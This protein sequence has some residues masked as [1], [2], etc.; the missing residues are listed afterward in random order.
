MTYFKTLLLASFTAAA[1]SGCYIH[2]HEGRYYRDGYYHH[3]HDHDSYRDR[4]RD[5][6]G[7][8]DQD[9]HRR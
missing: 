1:I 3:D 7:Y 6:D 2:D 4:H 8:R 9:R 5:R